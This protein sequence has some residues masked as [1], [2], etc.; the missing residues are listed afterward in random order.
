MFTQQEDQVTQKAKHLATTHSS[1]THT[2][3]HPHLKKH[4]VLWLG[5]SIGDLWDIFHFVYRSHSCLW[6]NAS[7][8]LKH[9]NLTIFKVG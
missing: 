3:T 8:K 5:E 4:S 6:E 7:C 2:H 9:F 1:D